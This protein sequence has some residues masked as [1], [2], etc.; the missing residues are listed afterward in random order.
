MGGYEIETD[1]LMEVGRA[2]SASEKLREREHYRVE[3]QK[4]VSTT[5]YAW[6]RMKPHSTSLA[7]FAK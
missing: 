6:I 3:R 1:K 7:A 5:N 4:I 2:K